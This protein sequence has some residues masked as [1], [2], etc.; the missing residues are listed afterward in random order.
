MTSAAASVRIRSSSTGYA[1]LPMIL[2]TRT[3]LPMIA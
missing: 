2:V 1:G 3:A